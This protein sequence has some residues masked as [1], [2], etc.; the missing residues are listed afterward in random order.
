MDVRT[1]ADATT[2]AEQRATE[3]KAQIDA[4]RKPSMSLAFD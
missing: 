4:N 1:A 3:L 2:G